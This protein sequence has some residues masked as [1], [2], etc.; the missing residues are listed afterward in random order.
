[1]STTAIA[2]AVDVATHL[3]SET[4]LGF[5]R[6]E[7][8]S[9]RSKPIDYTRAYNISKLMNDGLDP[10][11]DRV[12]VIRDLNGPSR[13][14]GHPSNVYGVKGDI[15]IPESLATDQVYMSSLD[16]HFAGIKAE[17]SKPS[18]AVRTAYGSFDIASD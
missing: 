9:L 18:A 3:N 13:F 8:G 10:K 12:S 7:D 14:V 4:G 15:V 11:A 6:Q 5:T 1:M 16:E 17:L 2:H